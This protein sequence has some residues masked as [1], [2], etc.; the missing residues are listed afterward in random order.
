M[1]TDLLDP[2]H[3]GKVLLEEFLKP[4]GISQRG[5][6]RT[7]HVPANRVNDIVLGRRGITGDTALRFS[8]ALGTSPEF[9]IGLQADYELDMARIESLQKKKL[10]ITPIVSPS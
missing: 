4:L 7:I 3:P 9:W 1:N 5:F 8:E 6:A 2:I 10:K